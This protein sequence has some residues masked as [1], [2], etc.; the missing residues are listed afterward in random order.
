MLASGPADAQEAQT[1]AQKS[2]VEA[3]EHATRVLYTMSLDRDNKDAFARTGAV[4]QLVRQLKSGSEKSQAMA[5]EALPNVARM[6]ADLRIQV[7]QQLVILLGSNNADVRQRA[8]TVL[9]DN[10][11]EG[12]EG[13]K[14]QKQA[15]ARAPNRVNSQTYTKTYTFFVFVLSV[16]NV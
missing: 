10:K 12:G 16:K 11:S 5:S 4:V 15:A 6:S 1:D 7:T 2:K 9:R 8:G 14:H 13:K 3:Q